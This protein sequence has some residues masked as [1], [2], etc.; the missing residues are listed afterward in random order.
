[1]SNAIYCDHCEKLVSE[2]YS[3]KVEMKLHRTKEYS[4]EECKLDLCDECFEQLDS[5]IF[6]KMNIAENEKEVKA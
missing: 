6:A 5:W 2:E 4:P 1:M 3:K